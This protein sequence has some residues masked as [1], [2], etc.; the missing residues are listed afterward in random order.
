MNNDIGVVGVDRRFQIGIMPR[1][2]H[3]MD[4]ALAQDPT[5]YGELEVVGTLGM[6]AKRSRDQITFTAMN[7]GSWFF[8]L[9]SWFGHR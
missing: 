2:N 7:A 5:V 4:S 9:G 1:A 6:I 8:V 3:D